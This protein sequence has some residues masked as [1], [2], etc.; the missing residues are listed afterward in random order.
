MVD[1]AADVK[2]ILRAFKW[3]IV[4]DAAFRSIPKIEDAL[5]QSQHAKQHFER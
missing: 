5:P 3:V 4:G 2:A 1:V